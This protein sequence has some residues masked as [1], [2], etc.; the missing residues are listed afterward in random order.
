MSHERIN[1]LFSRSII[2]LLSE[3]NELIWIGCKQ[4]TFVWT[5]NNQGLFYSNWSPRETDVTMGDACCVM[6]SSQDGRWSQ[7]SCNSQEVTKF[8]CKQEGHL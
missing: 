5:H 4:N 2:F 6:D 8:I 1:Y 3:S 7:M